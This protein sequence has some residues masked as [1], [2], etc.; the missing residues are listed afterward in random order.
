MLSSGIEKNRKEFFW[1]KF[2]ISIVF[3]SFGFV[4]L[5]TIV[6]AATI[7][8]SPDSDNIR[9]D[10]VF[11]VEAKISSPK[12]LINAAEATIKFDNDR[13]E[14][15]ELSTGGSIFSL[16][17]KPP[18]F[19]N[20]DGK[21]SFVGGAPGGFKGEDIRVLKIIFFA[22]NDGEAKLNFQ[23]NT[24]L[25]LNDGSGTRI[26]PWLRPIGLNILK[27]L[28]EIAPKDEWQSVI[29]GDNIPPEPFEAVISRNSVIFNN[30]YFVSF[31]AVD[32]QSGIA[33]Y[34]IKEGG[35]DFTQAESPHLLK[36]QSL[37]NIIQVKAVDKAG[38]ERIAKPAL[39]APPAPASASVP[40]SYRN[41]LV[42]IAVFLVIILF[43]FFIAWKKFRQKIKK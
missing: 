16:W 32:G 41:V 26:S 22:K 9:Q 35:G 4:L 15:K 2:F 8:F 40:L 14:V 20:Q 30:Q 37:K 29:K 42:L 17:P 28:P 43:I 5:P 36:D 23:D 27:H 3:I 6:K 12:E 24:S 7:Y 25:F 21:I 18:V 38:N 1:Y 11:I 33:Y 31:F 13:L 34:Q 39:L 10:D 19:S